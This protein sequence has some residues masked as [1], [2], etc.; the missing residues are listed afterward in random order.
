MKGSLSRLVLAMLPWAIIAA[1]LY[2]ALFVRPAPVGKTV[3]PSAIEH[4]DRFYGAYRLESGELWLAGAHGKIVR[5]DA[6][7][8]RWQI[9]SSPKD[10]HFQDI[11]AWDSNRALAVG[12]RGTVMY[13]DDGGQSWAQIA[14]VPS[15]EVAN[16]LI[17]IKTYDDGEAW[18]VGE[19]GTILRSED[20]GQSW[21]RMRELEDVILNEIVRVDSKT[22][23]VVGEF[24]LVLRSTDNGINWSVLSV[25]T[26][27]S[28]TAVAFRNENV[29][30]IAGLQGV[31]LAT[32]D[33]GETWRN[34]GGSLPNTLQSPSS[35][36]RTISDLW[37]DPVTEHIFAIQWVQD[38]GMWVAT[39]AK[40]IWLTGSPNLDQWKSGRLSET[41]M[42][43]HTS[44]VAL[45]DG[46][47]FAGQNTGVWSMGNWAVID[48]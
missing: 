40:G 41:E 1:L 11:S 35:P 22:L 30:V 3:Q 28:L 8:E 7:R 42:A 29:G 14:D 34:V 26:E 19:F 37:T 18:A 47:L 20:Y 48:N 46:V 24:G 33:G 23:M 10:V 27:K 5:S 21:R 38:M 6:D 4:R 31:R 9:Q 45:D 17:D 44:I 32:N 36:G 39:G 43:W 2:V 13:T 16:K 15:N 12:N 25:P